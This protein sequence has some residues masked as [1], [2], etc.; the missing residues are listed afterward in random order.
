MAIYMA[1]C[2]L[3]S[4]R[5]R[6]NSRNKGARGEREFAAE[7]KRLTGVDIRRNLEQ[8][9]SGG[10]DLSGWPPYAFEVKRRE[11][12]SVWEAYNQAAGQANDEYTVPVLA[13]R[14]NRGPWLVV[15]A[16]TDWIGC[17][18]RKTD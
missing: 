5:G 6:M 1:G 2:V 3:H 12:L 11:K 13:I 4:K 10:F 15:V 18:V 17:N 7:I 8:S 9:R 16:L 14:R